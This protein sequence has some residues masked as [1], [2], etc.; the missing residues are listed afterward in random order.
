MT[1]NRSAKNR[2]RPTQQ[3]VW[4]RSLGAIAAILITL[5][6]LGVFEWLMPLLAGVDPEALGFALLRA[7]FAL[8]ALLPLASIV[9]I[10]ANRRL[11]R[12]RVC[13]IGF[14]AILVIYYVPLALADSPL[15]LS[16]FPGVALRDL[17]LL[18]MSL[19]LHTLAD[20]RPPLLA[21]VRRAPRPAHAGLTLPYGLAI[22]LGVMVQT[23]QARDST[24]VSALV[25]AYSVVAAL[26][27]L[28]VFGDDLSKAEAYGWAIYCVVLTTRTLTLSN[29]LL[30]PALAYFGAMPLKYLFLWRVARNGLLFSS[31]APPGEPDDPSDRLWFASP[32]VNVL[33]ETRIAGIGETRLAED[34]QGVATGDA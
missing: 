22:L 19:L 30:V 14:F 12:P 2:R 18:T 8:N 20:L 3:R 21:R 5:Q 6:K 32:A 31:E 27:I 26:R 10:F 13:L 28:R 16:S 29:T 34:I 23:V 4:K 17:A 24:T 9:W 33:R 25:S 11:D 7:C 15:P 1:R